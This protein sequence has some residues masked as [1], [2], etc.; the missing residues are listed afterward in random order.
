MRGF[1]SG[2]IHG[3]N[4]PNL[5]YNWYNWD[6]VFTRFSFLFSYPISTGSPTSNWDFTSTFF[7]TFT[8]CC[9]NCDSS[10]ATKILAD[11]DRSKKYVRLNT[12]VNYPKSIQINPNHLTE[13]WEFAQSGNKFEGL[14]TFDG[15]GFRPNTADSGHEGWTGRAGRAGWAGCRWGRIRC[16][17]SEPSRQ[18]GISVGWYRAPWT[19]I[20]T[21]ETSGSKSGLSRSLNVWKSTPY[22]ED[23]GCLMLIGW[24]PELQ[25]E[26]RVFATFKLGLLAFPNVTRKSVCWH[27]LAFWDDCHKDCQM[28]KASGPGLSPQ[29]VSKTWSLTIDDLKTWNFGNDLEWP[30]Q[31]NQD[32]AICIIFYPSPVIQQDCWERLTF[33]IWMGPRNFSEAMLKRLHWSL[34]N[35][36]W[37]CET[38]VLRVYEPLALA[39]KAGTKLGCW[40]V[41]HCRMLFRLFVDVSWKWEG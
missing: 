23:F 26:V 17:P 25:L 29:E 8:T 27:M 33:W 39:F 30:A 2:V 4:Y 12:E 24:I 34:E 3:Y 16:L 32:F 18:L 31:K 5:G 13:T 14:T 41:A 1:R 28:L 7:C 21:I 11:F 6:K 15:G 20:G 37:W 22:F 19:K 38:S 35:F 40:D 9:T 10:V 36:H